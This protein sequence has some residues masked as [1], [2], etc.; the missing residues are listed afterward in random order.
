[1][2]Y[3][4]TDKTHRKGAARERDRVSESFFLLS[5]QRNYQDLV[6]VS[7]YLL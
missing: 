6:E 1:M 3:K 7:S 2:K 4:V 5:F